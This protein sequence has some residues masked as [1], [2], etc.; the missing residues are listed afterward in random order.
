M[1]R[2]LSV[3]G[4]VLLVGAL[5]PEA[6]VTLARADTAPAKPLLLP[7]KTTLYQR[8]LTRPGAMLVAKP[9]T[10]GG[11]PVPPLS[12]FYVYGRD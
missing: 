8:V 11:Q 12:I 6:R 9:G 5:N 7:G 4:L 1:R 10:T 3:I 2:I